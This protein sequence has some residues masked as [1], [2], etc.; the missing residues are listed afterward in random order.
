MREMK[1]IGDFHKN[2][3]IAKITKSHVN[4][5]TNWFKTGNMAIK[6]IFDLGFKLVRIDEKLYTSEEVKDIIDASKG[7]RTFGIKVKKQ[8]EGKK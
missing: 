7:A 8:S 2:I 3:E 5:V 1:Q 6:Y 4:S